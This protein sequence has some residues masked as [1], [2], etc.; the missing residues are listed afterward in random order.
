MRTLICL[1]FLLFCSMVTIPVASA[2]DAPVIVPMADPVTPPARPDGARCFIIK[3]AAPYTIMGSFRTNF[4]EAVDGTQARSQTNFRMAPGVSE[5]YCTYGPF[6][7]GGRLE[8]ILRTIVPIFSCFT[9]AEGEIT[10]RGK[11]EKTGS[12]T[13]IECR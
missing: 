13:W 3:N 10:I 7:S 11:V 1:L 8:V 6:Y 4:F 5:E 12:K 2:Q 9:V